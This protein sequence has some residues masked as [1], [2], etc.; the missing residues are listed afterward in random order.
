MCD[1]CRRAISVN[2][3]TS[4]TEQFT[5]AH[6]LVGITAQMYLVDLAQRTLWRLRKTTGAGPRRRQP[7]R[8]RIPVVEV[9]AGTDPDTGAMLWVP[10]VDGT[11]RLGVLRLGLPDGADGND[12]ELRHRCSIVAGLAGHLVA[13]KLAYGDALN[14]TRRSTPLTVAAELLWQLLPTF[15]SRDLVITAVLEPHDRLGA[16]VSTTPSMATWRSAGSS[17]PLATTSKP[18]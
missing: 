7:S 15:T 11:E 8:A 1:H 18:V 10:I 9:F 14:V 5:W 2:G 16:T 4:H 6:G 13:T 17:T 12:P 3:A